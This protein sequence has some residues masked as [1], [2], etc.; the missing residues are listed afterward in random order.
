MWVIL[1]V[2]NIVYMDI[3][4]FDDRMKIN[5]L[6]WFF[7]WICLRLRWVIVLSIGNDVSLV[8]WLF[9][10][11]IGWSWLI[12]NVRLILILKFIIKIFV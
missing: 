10:I 5:I 8:N 2:I 1:V 7:F 9:W 6:K 3:M 4:V 11:K 12:R